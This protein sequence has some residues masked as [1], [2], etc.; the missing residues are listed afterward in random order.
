MSPLKGNTLPTGVRPG[1]DATA[2]TSGSVCK[3]E[4]SGTQRTALERVIVQIQA[5]G[6]LTAAELWAGLRHEVGI[7]NEQSLQARHFEPALLWLQQR[8]QQQ[9]QSHQ[10]R[11]LQQQ[12]TERLAV[13]NNRQAVSQYIRQ[14]HGQTVL[15]ALSIQQLQRLLEDLDSGVITRP[16]PKSQLSARFLLPA[17]L[18]ALNKNV[19]KVAAGSGESCEQ[20]WSQIHQ[21]TG[22]HAGDPIVS[23]LYPIITQYL[24]IRQ[25]LFTQKNLRLSTLLTMLKQAPT[26]AEL[27]RL[28]LSRPHYFKSTPEA[29]LSMP[30]SLDALN[31]IFMQRAAAAHSSKPAAAEVIP[32][33]FLSKRMRPY[34]AQLASLLAIIM[35]LIFYLFWR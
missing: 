23:R 27:Q 3:D 5:I 31:Q 1:S 19:V 4:L 16:E 24:Q 21:F 14:Y 25:L 6:H 10:L 12:L 11:R 33:N 32:L 7:G 22:L 34:Q 13:G 30:Q 18:H 20:I 2:V 8:L 35:L 26:T 17:E 29:R 28:E 15:S 9:Q